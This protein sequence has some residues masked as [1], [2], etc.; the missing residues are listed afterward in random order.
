MGTYN[1]LSN[2]T[3][4]AL[5]EEDSQAKPPPLYKVFLLNDDFT[6]MDFVV[7]VLEKFFA[8]DRATA[9]RI[10]LKIH[11]EGRGLCGIYPIDIARSKVDKVTAYAKANEYPLTCVIEETQ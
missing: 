5:L 1:H 3:D 2:K 4:Q 8:M 6:P 11:H 9:N 7:V 10:M